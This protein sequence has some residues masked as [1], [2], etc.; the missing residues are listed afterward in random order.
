MLFRQKQVEFAKLYSSKLFLTGCVDLQ[1]I[2]APFTD[3]R[4]VVF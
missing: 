1:N 3:G 2:R 4:Y